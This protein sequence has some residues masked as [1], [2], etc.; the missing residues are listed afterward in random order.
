MEVSQRQIYGGRSRYAAAQN[1]LLNTIKSASKISSKL[2]DFL[3]Q[4]YT[5]TIYDITKIA[6]NFSQTNE[7]RMSQ[8]SES[9]IISFYENEKSRPNSEEEESSE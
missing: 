3:M 5:Y 8:N 6:S 9:I 1:L 2:W 7:T 4:G